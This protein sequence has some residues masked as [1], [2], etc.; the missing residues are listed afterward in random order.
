MKDPKDE[1]RERL[2]SIEL[3]IGSINDQ[4]GRICSDIES[5]KGTRARINSSINSALEEIRVLLYGKGDAVGFNTRIDRLE[6]AE[7]RRAFLITAISVS[8]IGLVLK[9]GWDLLRKT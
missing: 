7:K 9:T 1:E 4:L 8:M 2:H 6:Q 5:E 3:K